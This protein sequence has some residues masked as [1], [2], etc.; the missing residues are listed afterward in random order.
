MKNMKRELNP[1]LFGDNNLSSEK[2]F[3]KQFEKQK[4][5]ENSQLLLEQR[6]AEVRVHVNALSDHLA[7]VITQ[8]N[9]FI[10]NSQHKF[11]RIQ[12]ALQHLEI[13][14]QNL[15][16]DSSQQFNLFQNKLTER[17]SMD[18]KIQEMIDRHNSNLKTYEVRLHQMQKI[19]IERETQVT[20]TQALLNETKLEVARLKKL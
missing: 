8:I 14:D 19:L 4:I 13:N 1:A 12:Q 3:E 20:S 6:I 11:D 7:K 15:S 18:L 16:K 2:I 9:E 10:K 17:K 5:D